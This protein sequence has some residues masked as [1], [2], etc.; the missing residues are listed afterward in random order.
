MGDGVRLAQ[1]A[2]T[3]TLHL[4]VGLPGVGK[5]TLARTIAHE[6][7]A[8]RLTPDEWMIPLFGT[9]WRESETGGKRDVLEGRLLWTAHEVL[10]AGGSVVLDFGCWSAAERWA[11]R[12]VA[13]HASGSFLLHF[14]DLPEAERRAR[15][16]ARWRQTRAP[17]SS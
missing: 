2:E 12:A 5:T 8:V 16:K 3:P 15:A 1:M 6:D 7:K 9:T 13:E 10:G 11:V 17:P 4:T 14:V